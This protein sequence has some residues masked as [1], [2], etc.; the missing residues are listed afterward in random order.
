MKHGHP[1]PPPSPSAS[2]SVSLHPPGPRRYVPDPPH[3]LLKSFSTLFSLPLLLRSFSPSGAFQVKGPPC[4]LPPCSL[5]HS[6]TLSPAVPVP[7]LL[8]SARPAPLPFYCPTHPAVHPPA[9]ITPSG[10]SAT[11]S[12]LFI[13]AVPYSLPPSTRFFV[14]LHHLII[15]LKPLLSVAA[16]V[17]Q[18][19]PE[20][21]THPGALVPHRTGPSE[22][23]GEYGRRSALF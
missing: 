2:L 6:L 11:L 19:C 23:T 4:L 15:Q 7:S 5:V 10:A 20:S 3:L 8:R 13:P 14:S 21:L 16:V 1:A 12:P 9:Y 22:Q 17:L 18:C